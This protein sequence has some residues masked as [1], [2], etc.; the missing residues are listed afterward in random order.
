MDTLDQNL[1][2]TLSKIYEAGKKDYEKIKKVVKSID[3]EKALAEAKTIGAK[4]I[5]TVDNIKQQVSTEVNR[6]VD[7]ASQ[8]QQ[9]MWINEVP[10]ANTRLYNIYNQMD[11]DKGIKTSIC[12]EYVDKNTN[13]VVRTYVYP[14]DLKYISMTKQTSHKTE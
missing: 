2:D 4:A 14:D 13:S 12:I 8:Y 7:K 10:L 5:D 3:Y 9:T 11:L 1:V 6:I